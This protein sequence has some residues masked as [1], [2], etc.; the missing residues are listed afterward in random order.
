MTVHSLTFQLAISAAA[1]TEYYR[2]AGRTVQVRT[3][4]G[5]TIRFPASALQAYITRDGIHGRFMIQFDESNRLIG[6][7]KI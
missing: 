5:Q 7:Q 4:A 6:I 2:G 1:F 3:E